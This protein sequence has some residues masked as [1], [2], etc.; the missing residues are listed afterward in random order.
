MMSVQVGVFK[1]ILVHCSVESKKKKCPAE[2]QS[3]SSGQSAQ[4]QSNTFHF[5]VSSK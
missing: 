3:P 5:N 1:V 4:L 2:H